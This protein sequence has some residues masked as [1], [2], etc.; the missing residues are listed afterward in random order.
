MLLPCSCFYTDTLGREREES[1]E[2]AGGLEKWLQWKRKRR[3]RIKRDG[4]VNCAEIGGE[5]A[6]VRCEVFVC[7]GCFGAD[8]V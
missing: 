5:E 6:S 1:R 4:G 3:V 7:E 8:S 2:R